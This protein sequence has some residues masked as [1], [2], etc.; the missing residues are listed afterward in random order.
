MPLYDPTPEE[1]E[2]YDEQMRSDMLRN[3]SRPPRIDAS[4][5]EAGMTYATT[6]YGSAASYAINRAAFASGYPIPSEYTRRVSSYGQST[7][8]YRPVMYYT[9]MDRAQALEAAGR[10][11]GQ[12][13]IPGEMQR[14][15]GG[16]PPPAEGMTRFYKGYYEPTP[17][18]ADTPPEQVLRQEYLRSEASRQ[19]YVQHAQTSTDRVVQSLRAGLHENAQATHQTST[20]RIVQD[21][22]SGLFGEAGVGAG[23]GGGS[24]GGGGRGTGGPGFIGPNEPEMNRGAADTFGQQMARGL[25]NIQKLTGLPQLSQTL[26]QMQLTTPRTADVLGARFVSPEDPSQ[27]TVPGSQVSDVQQRIFNEF[28]QAGRV[29]QN[30]PPQSR[31]MS[32]SSRMYNVTRDIGKEMETQAKALETAGSPEQAQAV[33]ELKTRVTVLSKDLLQ[34]GMNALTE[35]VSREL[36]GDLGINPQQMNIQQFSG[37]LQG[38]G[39][40]GQV[41]PVGVGQIAQQVASIGGIGQVAAQGATFQYTTPSGV[42]GA[43][44]VPPGGQVPGGGGGGGGG[45]RGGIWGGDLG[46]LMYGGY[47]ARRFWSYTGAPVMRAMEGYVGA[48]AGIAPMMTGQIPTEGPG[49]YVADQERGQ[50]ALGEAAY[51]LIGGPLQASNQALQNPFVADVAAGSGLLGGAA[52]SARIMGGALSSTLGQTIGARLGTGALGRIGGSLSGIAAPALGVASSIAGG[53]S[54]GGGVANWAIPIMYPGMET[55][56]NTLTAMQ[57]T[58]QRIGQATAIASV[59]AAGALGFGEQ[60]GAH[61]QNVMQNTA[62]GRFLS[63]DYTGAAGIEENRQLEALMEATG[64]SQQQLP[65][66]MAPIQGLT[67]QTGIGGV[68]ARLAAQVAQAGARGIGPS[69]AL[70]GAAGYAEALGHLPGQGAFGTAMERY[71]AASLEEQARM[72]QEAQSAAG[73]GAQIREFI[74]RDVIGD[75]P[76]NQ[77]MRGLTGQQANLLA[78]GVGRLTYAGMGQ[79][80]AGTY[81]ASLSQA[82]ASG[83]MTQYQAQGATTLGA[84]FQEA[85]AG[86]APTFGAM[87][88]AQ[89]AT[90]DQIGIAT[91]AYGGNLQSLSYGANI[92]MF[93]QGFALSDLAG[94]PMWDVNLG[95]GIA[96]LNQLGSGMVAQGAGMDQMNG[97]VALG[98]FKP[99]QNIQDIQGLRMAGFGLGTAMGQVLGVSGTMQSFFDQNPDAGLMDYQQEH[100]NRMYGFQQAG[101]GIGMQK[102]ALQRQFMYG[103]G[104]WRQPTAG[105]L[106]GI[107]DRMRSLQWQGQQASMQFSLESMDVQNQFAQRQEGIQFQR[108][109]AQQDM[110]RWGFGFQRAGMDLQRQWTMQDRQYQDQMRGLSTGWSLEDFDEQ[111]RMSGGRQR[112][113]LVRQRERFVTQTNLEDEQTEK[114]RER[115]EEMWAREDE[116]FEKRREYAETLMELDNQQFELSVERRTELYEM[117]REDLE[118]RIELAEKLHELQEEQI[119]KQR[120]FQIAQLDLSE[121]AL[122]IQ[123]ASAAAQKEYNDDMLD[124]YEGTLQPSSDAIQNIAN[125]ERAMLTFIDLL[126]TMSNINTYK[127]SALNH[128][129][130]LIQST[131]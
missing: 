129:I 24:I 56:Y 83:A 130:R 113:Q 103:G 73:R 51:N 53:F 79:R 117:N 125:N 95:Q 49:A 62:Y 80:M 96:N 69:A 86:M 15:R 109:G 81:M 63:Q 7:M 25:Q 33:R 23:A 3:I 41:G 29:Y 9:D 31:Y 72:S 105:S 108:M 75:V 11:A 104:D 111:I 114:Q 123:A 121:K 34:S 16:T 85:G 118:R 77:M 5:T 59:G 100:A 102:I 78:G 124:L 10:P 2:W 42:Q 44:Q 87:Q 127:L 82:L 6:D 115:Q 45:G 55:N 48:Q 32:M 110:Q 46:S 116:Q 58:F 38:A 18:T 120:E 106:W 65:Q 19:P 119:Q 128:T 8:P 47:I 71:G 98:Q 84:M 97:G 126:D 50:Y 89:G 90:A 13:E 28:S 67:G 92:G 1:Q 93:N 12:F 60:A 39:A 57:G 17:V 52:L 43:I 107:E 122:G 94:R 74:G 66:L 70:S 22:R 99:F 27:I 21:L 112:R 61:L 36:A 131:E 37:M 88:W 54:V 26:G 4:F 91:A 64:L 14:F 40:A 68:N 20:D 101:I 76:L 35:G 30:L